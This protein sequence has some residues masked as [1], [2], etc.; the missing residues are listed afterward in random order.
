MN[1]TLRVNIYKKNIFTDPQNGSGGFAVND[2]ANSLKETKWSRL[3]AF[4]GATFLSVETLQLK[5][6]CKY[7]CQFPGK[8]PLFS[9]VS[10][11]SDAIFEYE[12]R[13]KSQDHDSD[14]IPFTRR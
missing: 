13:F 8:F 14:P 3:R 6:F 10:T 5:H 9:L 7:G 2:G 4:N 11:F 12:S 1:N